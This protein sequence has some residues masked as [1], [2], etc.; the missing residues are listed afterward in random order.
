MLREYG[1]KQR[2]ISDVKGRNSRLDEIQAAILRVK[3]RYLDLDN[4]KRRK[5]AEF[6]SDNIINKY[7]KVPVMRNDIEPVFHLYVIRCKWRDELIVDLGAKGIQAG[8]HYP[9]PIHLQRAY[10]GRIRT[11][12][13]MSV[14]ETLASEV[15]SLPMYPELSNTEIKQVVGAINE[16]SQ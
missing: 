2:Y 9:V 4:A 3:L 1:W 13:D 12:S 11:A 15:M 6:Y 16:Y 5:I 7:V 8:I 14:T 10:K